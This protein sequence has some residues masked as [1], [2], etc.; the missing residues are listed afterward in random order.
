MTSDERPLSARLDAYITNLQSIADQGEYVAQAVN[1]KTGAD[2]QPLIDMANLQRLI[3]D[4][5]TKIVNGE[6]LS[7]FRIEGVI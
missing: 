4:D 1:A 7:E 5:L 3:A 2:T 6:K